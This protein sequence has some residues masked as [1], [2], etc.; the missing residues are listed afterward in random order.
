[1]SSHLFTMEV[2]PDTDEVMNEVRKEAFNQL[3]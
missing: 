1:M 3:I 2:Q